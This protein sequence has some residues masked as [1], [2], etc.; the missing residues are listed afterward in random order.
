[1]EEHIKL[2]AKLPETYTFNPDDIKNLQKI[3]NVKSFIE[4]GTAGLGATAKL[5]SK[6]FEEVHT[7]EIAEHYFKEATINLRECENVKMY[8]GDTCEKFNIL[9]QNSKSTRLYWLDA[10][11][12]GGDT[13]GIPGFSPIQNSLDQ[14]KKYGDRSD[15]IMID[16]IRGEYTD[17]DGFSLLFEIA[18]SIENIYLHPKIL[19]IG[20][21]LLAFDK[22]IHDVKVKNYINAITFSLFFKDSKEPDDIKKLF[23]AEKLI[24]LINPNSEEGKLIYNLSKNMDINNTSGKIIYYLWGALIDYGS[25]NYTNA[26]KKFDILINSKFNHWRFILYKYLILKTLGNDL[27]S[28]KIY[29]ENI[30]LFN[31]YYQYIL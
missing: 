29:N 28:E 13:G 15:V 8:F 2:I 4:T 6:I 1:M 12:S 14:I 17:K 19:I 21:I 22:E 24:R 3:F 7:I 23:E 18:K 16:D 26:I 9:I 31:K 30:E 10:H 25:N 27:D 11:C 20:D 5:A